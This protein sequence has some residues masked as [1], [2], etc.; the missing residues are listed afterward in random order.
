MEEEKFRGIRVRSFR[1]LAKRSLTWSQ[2]GLTYGQDQKMCIK[3]PSSTPHRQ[4]LSERSENIFLSEIGVR[5]QQFIFGF[6]ISNTSSRLEDILYNFTSFCVRK[7]WVE[8][9]LPL[10]PVWWSFSRMC[11]EQ[12]SVQPRDQMSSP[13]WLRTFLL[14]GS[15]CKKWQS[16]ICHQKPRG[17]RCAELK[18]EHRILELA[19][20]RLG[21]LSWTGTTSS[22]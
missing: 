17:T 8:V 11:R 6:P 3:F 16:C 2:K 19:K 13:P 18:V 22:L 7:L 1:G 9:S 12:D 14:S 20:Q 5:Y 10:V 15:V 21:Q 4:H